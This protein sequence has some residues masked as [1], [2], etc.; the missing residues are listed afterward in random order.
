MLRST[1]TLITG[2]LVAAA[3][4]AQPSQR[5][6]IAGAPAP[7]PDAAT[8]SAMTG[9]FALSDGRALR[10]SRPGLNL[11]AAVGKR[12]AVTLEPAGGNRFVSR[13][14]RLE[15]EF[16]ADLDSLRLVESNRVTVAGRAAPAPIWR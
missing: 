10:V 8:L 4:A 6:E 1:V 11:M 9:D 12:W 3:A 7:L 16:D 15:V 14:G 5:V 13:D 2:L